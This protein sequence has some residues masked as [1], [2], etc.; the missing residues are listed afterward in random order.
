[1]NQIALF[2]IASGNYFPQVKTL[3]NSVSDLH[4]EID[5]YFFLA[6]EIS[7]PITENS[8]GFKV[9]CAKQLNIENFETLA[10]KYNIIEFNT[11]IK[12]FCFDY[13]FNIKKY[14]KIIYLDPDIYVFNRLDFIINLLH[15]YSILF[16][17]H[18]ADKKYASENFINI[19]F[20]FL[21]FGVYNLGF[22]ALRKDIESE[23]LLEWWK[24]RCHDNCYVFKNDSTYVDQKWMDLAPSLF[25]N[26]HIIKHLGCNMAYWNIQERQLNENLKVNNAFDL[27]FFHFSGFDF[28][29]EQKITSNGSITYNL[30]NRS[31]LK[32]IFDTYR[33]A[34]S[35]NIDIK[36]YIPEYKYSKFENGVSITEYQRNIYQYLTDIFTNPFSLQKPSFYHFAK[37]RHKLSTI[38]NEKADFSIDVLL[39]KKKNLWYVKISLY[40]FKILHNLL[41]SIKFFS[42]ANQTKNFMV[43][44]SSNSFL[45]ES[46][47]VNKKRT[48]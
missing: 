35:K 12:P 3:L 48:K 42:L 14:Q 19:E 45:L 11:A 36:N 38:S 32:P 43:Y 24:K 9:I 34:I 13:L 5:L 10:F 1:M 2:T 18:I 4:T 21:R 17:P 40:I 30:D 29:D 16:T 47:E 8:D 46:N 31:D 27:L 26:I 7:A 15:E 6:D 25:D 28:K 41:G 37:K 39:G 22:V 23:Y 44:L 33:K 20:S